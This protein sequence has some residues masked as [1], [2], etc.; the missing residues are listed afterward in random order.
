MGL[1][2]FYRL[3][4]KL[5]PSTFHWDCVHNML[6]TSVVNGMTQDA[7]AKIWTC[8]VCNGKFQ[9]EYVDAHMMAWMDSN[10]TKEMKK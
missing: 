6:E 9:G 1:D 2:I 5:G 3:E 4:S 7:N 10:F 8:P